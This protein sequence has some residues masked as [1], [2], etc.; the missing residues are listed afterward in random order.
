MNWMK[1]FHEQKHHIRTTL[2]KDGS[3]RLML[4]TC[5]VLQDK[6]NNLVTC[7]SALKSTMLLL[8]RRV[9]IHLRYTMYDVRM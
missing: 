9:R 6:G 5:F 3:F 4:Y 8:S 7:S 1:F 2:K